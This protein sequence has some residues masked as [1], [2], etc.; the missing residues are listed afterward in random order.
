MKLPAGIDERAG[1]VS[2][3]RSSRKRFVERRNEKADG[4]CLRGCI[5]GAGRAAVLADVTGYIRD[6][7][8]YHRH[9][10]SC[11]DRRKEKARTRSG[12]FRIHPIEAGPDAA[13]RNRDCN[14]MPQQV[15]SPEGTEDIP[16][17]RGEKGS[18]ENGHED[19]SLP[20]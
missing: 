20:G 10:P 3:A 4:C 13:H 1:G 2:R 7:R 17:K 5:G 8:K 19:R 12:R 15:A 16:R 11:D 9:V 6:D 14:A 18:R